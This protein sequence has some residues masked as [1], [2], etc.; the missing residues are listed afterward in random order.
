MLCQPF[1]LLHCIQAGDLQNTAVRLRSQLEQGEAKRQSLEYQL[2]LT[3]KDGRKNIDRLDQ[4]EKEWKTTKKSLEGLL[5]LLVIQH[6]RSPT[7]D[8]PGNFC[9]F[10]FQ[11]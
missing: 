10:K 9:W 1:S 4:R 2:A 5:H 7:Y 6:L 11:I 8:I 3:H